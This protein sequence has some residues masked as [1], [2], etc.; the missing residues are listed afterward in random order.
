MTGQL[1]NAR[2]ATAVVFAAHGCVT[3]S[4]AARV[5]WIAQHV[6]VDVGHLGLALLMPG[7]GAVVAMPFSGRLAHRFAFRPLVAATV[8]AWCAALV[9]PALPTSLALLCVVM[10]AFGATAGLADMAMNA[11]AVA[12][13]EKFL[14]AKP[15]YPERKK[16]E[17]Y[18]KENK[19]Q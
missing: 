1:R 19:K 16:L 5:P 4:F 7:I 17:Q 8:P 12:E 10:L 14:A 9:L 11:E 6:G 3:G 13:C 18:I 15:D 2:R